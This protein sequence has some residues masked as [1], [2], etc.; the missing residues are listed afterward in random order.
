MQKY[1]EDPLAEEILKGEIVEGT[2][3]SV[4]LDK[5]NNILKVINASPKKG[6]KP[7]VDKGE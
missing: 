5:E 3:V 7:K 4:E 6:R 1:L 2:S